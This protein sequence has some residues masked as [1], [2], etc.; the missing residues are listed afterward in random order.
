MTY[1]SQCRIERPLLITGGLKIQR[2]NIFKKCAS[3]CQCHTCYGLRLTTALFPNIFLRKTTHRLAQMTEVAF[4]KSDRAR[5][6]GRLYSHT[7]VMLHSGG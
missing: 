6:D 5:T 4:S 1:L 2:I 7:Q 3:E